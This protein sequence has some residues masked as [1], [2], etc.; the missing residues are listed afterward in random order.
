MVSSDSAQKELLF[1][2]YNYVPKDDKLLLESVNI[3]VF[4]EL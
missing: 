2:N 4:T 3:D 1:E